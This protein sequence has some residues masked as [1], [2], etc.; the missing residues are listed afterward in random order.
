MAYNLQKPDV[1]IWDWDG[2]VVDTLPNVLDAHNH[3]RKTLQLPLWNWDEFLVHAHGSTGDVYPRL[4]GDRA[5]ECIDLLYGYFDTLDPAAITYMDKGQ[6]TVKRL[7]E[8]NIPNI[9]V[10]NK[11]HHILLSELE[12]S[13]INDCFLSV[14]G[15]GKAQEDKPTATPVLHALDLVDVSPSNINHAWFIGDSQTDVDCALNLPFD[16]CSIVVG[17]NETQ[18]HNI[19]FS[20]L[21]LFYAYV[22]TFFQ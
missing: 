11:R 21:S 10:S 1:I 12:H 17:E 16:T 2:T 13:P 8:T 14:V 15:A 18:N 5:Q 3:V 20:S 6:D 19:Q 4:Y 7:Y 22:S 9:L